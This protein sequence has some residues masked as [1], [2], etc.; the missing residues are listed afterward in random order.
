MATLPTYFSDFLKDV[1]PTENQ[2][3]DLRQGHSTLRRRLRE[4]EDLAPLIVSDFL[5]GS[6]RRSTVVRP[7]GDKR[8]DVD[9][10]VVTRISKDEVEPGDAMGAFIPFLEKHYKDKWRVQGRSFGIELSYVEMDLVIT[11]A[12]SESELGILEQKAVTSDDSLGEAT[13]WR[14]VKGWIPPMERA[15]F[16]NRL[17]LEKALQ[18]PEWKTVPLWI[19]DREINKWDETD[20][21][22]QIIWT[23]DKNAGCNGYYLSTVQAIKWWR[24]GFEDPAR[25]KGYPVEHLI[26]DCCTDGI[27]SVAEGVVLTLETFVSRYAFDVAMKRVPFLPDHGVPTHDV[28]GRVSTSEFAEFYAKVEAAAQIA[29]EAYDEPDTTKSANRWRDL[30]GSKFPEPPAP[31]SKQGGFTQRDQVTTPAGGRFA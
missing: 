3:N 27:G 2:R 13:D 30:F 25:P 29:R 5:Q 20:P 18:Q 9:I 10:I 17:L 19:P 28:M 31:V 1:R 8:S 22:A 21:L 4:D 12:P 24:R 7:K 14:L 23:R 11:A 15:T 26:G 16:A 6:Y